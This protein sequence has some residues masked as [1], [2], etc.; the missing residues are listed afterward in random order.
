LEREREGKMPPPIK[1]G[2]E[3]RSRE[4]N[5]G[6]GVQAVIFSTLSTADN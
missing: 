4:E 3:R 6:W 2:D 1:G 5:W